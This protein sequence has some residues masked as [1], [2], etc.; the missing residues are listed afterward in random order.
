MEDK[1]F[2]K[3]LKYKEKYSFLKNMI[4][5]NKRIEI[6]SAQLATSG[7]YKLVNLVKEEN[8]LYVTLNDDREIKI[9]YDNSYPFTPPDIIFE[10]KYLHKKLLNWQPAKR[11]SNILDD[12]D[13]YILI[14]ISNTTNPGDVYLYSGKQ[15]TSFIDITLTGIFESLN[16][17]DRKLRINLATGVINNGKT[18]LN[19]IKFELEKN[20][21]ITKIL[22]GG[23]NLTEISDEDFEELKNK[24]A[25][26]VVAIYKINT[27]NEFIDMLKMHKDINKISKLKPVATNFSGV[28]PRYFNIN[29][30]LYTPIQKKKILD[31]M[32]T[33]LNVK[34]NIYE[35]KSGDGNLMIY[36]AEEYLDKLSKLFEHESLEKS[37]EIISVFNPSYT[38]KVLDFIYIAFG[39][40][41]ITKFKK[42]EDLSENGQKIY[43]EYMKD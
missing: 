35:G 18:L 13:Q 36:Y 39:D 11:L 3:Y 29:W 34:F 42:L 2:K 4:G 12:F 37:L 16:Y 31:E 9:K 6:E 19:A 8:T 1:Y 40:I 25:S 30:N 43:G 21:I 10:D 14:P 20:N 7:K 27:I 24:G 38:S 33:F 32:S 26:L 23:R 5:G 17:P 41:D 22:I 15:S 28:E